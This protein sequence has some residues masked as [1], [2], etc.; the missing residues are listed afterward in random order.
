MT[1]QYFSEAIAMDKILKLNTEL[2]IMR[3]KLRVI[4][5]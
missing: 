4:T 3:S 1:T 5:Q 2:K